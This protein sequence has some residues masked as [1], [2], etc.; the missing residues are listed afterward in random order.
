MFSLYYFIFQRLIWKAISVYFLWFH[1]WILKEWK[2]A[3]VENHSV[4]AYQ[5]FTQMIGPLFDMFTGSMFIFSSVRFLNMCKPRTG[6]STSTGI[7]RK[8]AS[9][10]AELAGAGECRLT[11]FHPIRNF[12][13][14]ETYHF[15]RLSHHTGNLF[16]WVARSI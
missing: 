8:W 16:T 6:W 3:K 11:R 7:L 10:P 9:K 12:L 13:A 4:W 5:L 1:Y 15:S 14:N 2:A